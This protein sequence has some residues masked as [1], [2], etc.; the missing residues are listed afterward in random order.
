[1]S[2]IFKINNNEVFGSDG[3]FSGT[4]GSSATFPSGS[5]IKTY[6][7]V[8]KGTQ[9]IARG[10]GNAGL[11]PDSDFILVGT[12]AS[13]T[14]GS[15]LSITCDTPASNSSKY[16]IT[17]CVYF[18]NQNNGSTYFK[19]FYNNS[20]IS[21]DTPLPEVN[22]QLASTQTQV[23]LGYGH[24]G[25]NQTVHAMHNANMTYLWSP[26]SSLA[27]TISIKGISYS[28]S[29]FTVNSTDHVTDANY[30]SKGIS[31]LTIQEI[32]G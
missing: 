4:I 23:H 13:G 29:D 30:N 2:G 3:T 10:N 31:T 27:Q 28:T 18:S 22:S 17:A 9:S 25:N 19:L 20:G 16:L 14:S 6:Q 8:F 1:M 11:I 26:S 21:S 32:A 12:G 5:V 7:N 24:Q 15:P